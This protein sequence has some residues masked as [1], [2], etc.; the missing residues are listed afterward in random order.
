MH[1]SG[2]ICL[3]I[4]ALSATSLFS[5]QQA[6]AVDLAVQPVVV[7]IEGDAVPGVGN[8]TYVYNLVVNGN[9]RCYV[10]VDTDNP[11]T[12]IDGAIVMDSAATLYLQEGQAIVSPD[13]GTTI[14]TFDSM[15]L[16]LSGNLSHN[17]DL[18]GTPGGTLDNST[19]YFNTNWVCQEGDPVLWPGANPGT[20]YK[21]SYE[22]RLANNDLMLMLGS[23]DDPTLGG[24]FDYYFA[25]YDPST[26]AHT[27]LYMAGDP[28]PGTSL[29]EQFYN[30]TTSGS[31][32]ASTSDQFD[33]NNNGDLIFVGRLSGTTV[34]TANDYGIWLNNTLL[35]REGDSLSWDPLR[36]WDYVSFAEVGINDNGD[37]VYHASFDGDTTTDYAI[38]KNGQKF[39]QEGDLFQGFPIYSFSSGRVDISNH[40]DVLW[41]C[42]TTDATSQDEFVCVNEK[43]LVQEGVTQVGNSTVTQLEGYSDTQRMSD[44]GRYYVIEVELKDNTTLVEQEG[45]ILIDRGP[46]E[47]LGGEDAGSNGTPMLRGWGSL[48]PNAAATLDLMY[49]APNSSAYVVVSLGAIN[50]SPFKCGTLVPDPS[51]GIG[52]V[53]GPLLTDADGNLSWTANPNLPTGTSIW[54]QYFIADAGACD[55]YAISNAIRGTAP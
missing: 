49:A 55:G 7:V 54:A 11:S 3:L 6:L 37:Y 4:A 29:G 17:F 24:T 9:G 2:K 32:F 51:V 22:T 44:D 21:S 13:P 39:K 18:A 50:Q 28:A 35:V 23:C 52:F 53:R 45:A 31:C 5:A 43:V 48:E 20:V 25:T 41:Y 16:N 15:W 42:D 40:G 47:I 34:T 30:T 10:E 38:V 12:T 1:G 26:G 46:W 36:T 8:V 33:F 27:K 19:F 14:D